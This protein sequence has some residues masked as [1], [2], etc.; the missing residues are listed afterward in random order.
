M[1]GFLQTRGGARD[2]HAV[3]RPS[4]RLLCSRGLSS[5][6]E[7]NRCTASEKVDQ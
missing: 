2:V 7:H 5:E 6:A 4:V 3:P 1:V